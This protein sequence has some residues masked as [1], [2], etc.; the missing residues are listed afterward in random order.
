MAREHIAR[1]GTRHRA[2]SELKGNV[3]PSCGVFATLDATASTT[4]TLA[5]TW[6]PVAGSFTNDPL[7]GFALVAGPPPGIEL[8][9]GFCTGLYEIDWHASLVKGAGTSEV[10]MGILVNG[11]EDPRSIQQTTVTTLELQMS[12]TAVPNLS[13]GDVITLAISSDTPGDVITLDFYTTTI[14]KFF[15]G[16]PD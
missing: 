13:T 11:V 7:V 15:V 10:R 12:G 2:G 14:K 16:T 6:Y 3:L 1:V 9:P 4:C 8:Q 5:D